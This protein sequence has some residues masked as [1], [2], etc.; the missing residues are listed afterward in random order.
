[1]RSRLSPFDRSSL[2]RADPP[3]LPPKCHPELHDKLFELN[4]TFEKQFRFYYQW[5]AD[6]QYDLATRARNDFSNF[7]KTKRLH[8][9]AESRQAEAKYKK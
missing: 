4:F 7:Y 9:T 5:Y 8:E 3:L 1:M 2:K 6:H